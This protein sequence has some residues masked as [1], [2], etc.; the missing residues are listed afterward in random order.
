MN[1]NHQTVGVHKTL[2]IVEAVD[3]H[4]MVE[5]TVNVSFPLNLDLLVSFVENMMM[6]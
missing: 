2:L 3:A 5:G 1:A 6:V 4:F